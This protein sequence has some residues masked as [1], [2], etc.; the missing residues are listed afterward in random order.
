[1]KINALWTRVCGQAKGTVR[2]IEALRKAYEH[3]RD[4]INT[5][6]RHEYAP[7][8]QDIVNLAYTLSTPKMPSIQ[9]LD[10]VRSDITYDTINPIV[11]K[12]RIE[13][14]GSDDIPFKSLVEAGEWIYAESAKPIP[15]DMVSKAKRCNELRNNLLEFVLKN[16]T[17][18]GGERIGL[19]VNDITFPGIK[20]ENKGW[21]ESVPVGWSRSLGI[22]HNA[23]EQIGNITNLPQYAISAYI[24]TG[25]KT[26]LP[27]YSLELRCNYSEATLDSWLAS[28]QLIIKINSADLTF[29]DLKRIYENYRRQ[30]SS[31]RRKKL[32][33]KQTMI[34]WMV[35]KAG[36]VPETGVTDFWKSIQ[37]KWNAEHPDDPYKSWE[38]IY[39]AYVNVKNKMS[40]KLDMLRLYGTE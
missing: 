10:F 39:K 19:I 34:Y 7:L 15:A 26:I 18:G 12:A 29:D 40:K 8:I 30:L 17:C 6:K 28:T 25:I 11:K 1:M 5:A 31:T 32:S 36:G 20:E 3:Y 21:T 35:N 13:I 14:F 16:G 37:S 38:G 2:D 27:K 24:L 33:D 9:D 23:I 4:I 22:L